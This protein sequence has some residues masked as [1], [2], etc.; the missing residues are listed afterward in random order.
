MFGYV[1]PYRPELKIREFEEY[2]A[3]YCGL[4]KELGRS[5]GLF[6]RFTLS[7]DFAFLSMVLAALDESICISSKK[8][9]CIAHP[10]RKQSCCRRN[11]AISL[12]ATAAVVLTYYKLL[13]DVSD[14]G[15][16][17]K[18]SALL[19]LPFAKKAR[20]KAVSQVG[21]ALALDEAAKIMTKKQRELEAEKCPVSDKAAEPTAK[22]LEAVLAITAGGNENER[23]L[24]RFGYLL[25]RYIYLCDALD[26][27]DDDIKKSNYNPFI[28]AEE[29]AVESAKSAL[30]LTTA[31]LESDLS[32]L[33][34]H[35]Y[36]GI[37]E[38]IVCLGLRSEV[39]RIIQK[40]GGAQHGT[41]PI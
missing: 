17:K 12:S 37:I 40:K 6:A 16:F 34:L 38:N 35:Q 10:F 27:I 28:Y 23:I 25:G 20:K 30:F 1:K 18:I 19:M 15:F 9:R 3:V 5:Y 24:K 32:L 36:K 41:Q 7:Y 26:D 14:R 21:E 22:F 11:G 39:E 13:D 31:E 8:C 29:G 33:E 4:C 2:K